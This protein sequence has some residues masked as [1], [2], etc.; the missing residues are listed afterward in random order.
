MSLTLRSLC[1]FLLT[2]EE[3]TKRVSTSDTKKNSLIPPLKNRFC[4][5]GITEDIFS[6]C[7]RATH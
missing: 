6:E 2:L 3:L 7:L 1:F 5:F 4:S